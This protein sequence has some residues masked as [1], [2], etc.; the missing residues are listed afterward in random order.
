ADALLGLRLAELDPADLDR[1][2]AADLDQ[3][4]REVIER[5]VAERTKARSEKNWPRAD[6]IRAELDHLGV[7]V[8]D[9]PTGPT[10][11]LRLPANPRCRLR[12]CA[13]GVVTGTA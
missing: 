6:E 8:T 3:A 5:L 4:E 11:H 7:Q 13:A 2:S 10:W 9:T 12:R 1:R